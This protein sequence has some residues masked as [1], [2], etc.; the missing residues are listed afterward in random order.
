MNDLSGKPDKRSRRTKA[1]MEEM[2][3]TIK[4]IVED[5]HPLTL[6]RLYYRLIGAGKIGKSESEYD[7]V[8]NMLISL[9]ERGRVP[10]EHVIDNTRRLEVPTTFRSIG[11]GLSVIDQIYRR[12]PWLDQDCLVVVITEKDALSAILYGETEKLVVPL[13]VIHG[14]SSRTFLH[15]IAE[16]IKEAGKPT[17]VY[18]F[19]DLDP[20]GV[21]NI[22]KPSERTIRRYAPHA[23]IHWKR[24]AVTKEQ[25]VE[26]TLITRETKT[27]GKKN[28][29][30]KSPE[31]LAVAPP[32]GESCEVD[33]M[34][35]GAVLDLLTKAMRSRSKLNPARY[36][37]T[38]KRERRERKQLH[39]LISR[40][41]GK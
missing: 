8:G 11:H 6:R 39:G 4:A 23:R 7:N 14:S 27:S 3:T 16:K 25:I 17:F 34:P 5:E 22:E 15:D 28:D 29:I 33:A 26:H 32:N 12:D 40:Y 37:K 31:W 20:A 36:A 30:S 19:G 13:G 9:R 35:T 18:Y 38:L 41:S 10:W 1:E 21:V 24:L 2:Y